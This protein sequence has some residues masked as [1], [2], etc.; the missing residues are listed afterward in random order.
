[1]CVLTQSCA[2]VLFS[3][4]TLLA[5]RLP[6]P[7]RRQ[8]AAT[9]WYLKPQLTFSDALAAVRHAIWREQSLATS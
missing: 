8:V 7:E 3:I 5:T 6:P 1:M 4:V 9:A 2:V